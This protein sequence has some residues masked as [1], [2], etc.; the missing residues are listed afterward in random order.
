MK[1]IIY[2]LL[3]LAC[4]FTLS[5]AQVGINTSTP[6]NSALLDIVSVDKGIV[7]PRVQLSATNN[8]A[9]F[10]SAAAIQEGTLV[11][12]TATAGSGATKVF[13]NVYQ[14]DGVHS[15]WIFPASLDFT[16]YIVAQ[17]RNTLNDAT[18][19]N[20]SIADTSVKMGIFSTEVFNDDNTVFQRLG[21]TDL[22]ILKPGIYSVSLNFALRQ[23]PQ[24]KDSRLHTYIQPRLNSTVIG[25][26]ISTL[27]PQ[28]DPSQIDIDGRFAF[29]LTAYFNVTS[30]ST[31][32]IISTRQEDGNNYSGTLIFDSIGGNLSSITILKLN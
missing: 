31:L 32:S 19:F 4:P 11:Y 7:I 12:N 29:G 21:S 13:P 23:N 22:R 16:P 30:P 1:P 5:H 15:K 27:V 8:P 3:F 20:A 14:W 18:N 6:N 26:G 25:A 9:P 24:V 2:T 10:P 17:Y 28:Y